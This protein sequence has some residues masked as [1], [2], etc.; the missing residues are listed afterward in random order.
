MAGSFGRIAGDSA[1][2]FGLSACR[3]R[4]WCAGSAW[5]ARNTQNVGAEIRRPPPPIPA[6]PCQ[7]QPVI[8]G[9]QSLSAAVIPDLSPWRRV[10]RADAPMKNRHN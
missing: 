2:P 9:W 5:A 6:R 1:I 7:S 4:E 10:N 3:A 8:Y